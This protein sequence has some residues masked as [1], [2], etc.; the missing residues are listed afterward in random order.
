[1]QIGAPSNLKLSTSTTSFY[2]QLQVHGQVYD[3]N[4][5]HCVYPAS[6]TFLNSFYTLGVVML[7]VMVCCFLVFGV[8]KGDEN[9]LNSSRRGRSIDGSVGSSGSHH[10]HPRSSC[11]YSQSRFRDEDFFEDPEQ[12]TRLTN[13]HGHS[14][15]T[16]HGHSHHHHNH[17][18]HTSNPNGNTGA[19]R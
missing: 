4:V 15:H 9:V 10:I 5:C 16:H 2:L 3:P 19:P 14:H 18:H 12:R 6:R 1:M 11:S 7:T 13:H 8:Q 17:N